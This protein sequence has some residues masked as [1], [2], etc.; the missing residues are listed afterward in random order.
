MTRWTQRFTA[1]VT[2]SKRVTVQ[3]DE[4]V[5]VVGLGSVSLLAFV[6]LSSVGLSSV[7]LSVNSDASKEAESY[8]TTSEDLICELFPAVVETLRNE[9]EDVRSAAL[10]FLQAYA[11]KLKSTKKR[12]LALPEVSISH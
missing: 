7:G 2:S 6:G 12:R 11:N 3:P 4:G 5:D 8:V 9:D 1:S 10:P